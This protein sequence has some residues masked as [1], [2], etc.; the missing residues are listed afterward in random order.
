MFDLTS[1]EG[2]GCILYY[3]GP[4]KVSEVKVMLQMGTFKH[5]I[6]TPAIEQDQYFIC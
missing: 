4:S 6:L 2:E 3:F 5:S 1:L